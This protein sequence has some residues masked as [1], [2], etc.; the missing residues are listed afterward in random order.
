MT[1]PTVG[2]TAAMQAY[3]GTEAGPERRTVEAPEPGPGEALVAVEAFSVNRGEL[4]LLDSRSEGWRPGQDIAGRILVPAADGSSPAAGTPV[5]GMVDFGGWAAQAALPTERLAVL[6]DG[7]EV[8]PTAAF[9]VAGLTALRALRRGAGLLGA[10]VLIT[11]ATGGVG[12]F[13]VQLAAAGGAEVTA[14]ARHRGDVD[15]A[16]LGAHRVIENLAVLDEDFD[17][18]LESVGGP[19]LLDALRL[20]A[21]HGHLVLL[22]TSSGQPAPIDI[23]SFRRHARQ[24]VHPFWVYGSG[25][26]PADDLAT[27]ASLHARRLLHPVIGSRRDWSELPELLDDLS[28]RRFPGKGLLTIGES[29]RCIR[30]FAYR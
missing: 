30:S 4:R 22:G 20:T 29:T 19:V 23:G 1:T 21:D 16:R 7:L 25:E 15:L 2:T 27:L 13:A 12:T 17:L 8:A 10:R 6:P 14:L 28:Q 3:V 11:G 5:A 18:V 26:R 9:G 24:T